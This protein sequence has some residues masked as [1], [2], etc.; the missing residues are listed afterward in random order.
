MAEAAGI[1]VVLDSGD[2][3]TLF[4]EDQARYLVACPF[5]AA[6]ALMVAAGHAGVHVETVGRF[7]GNAIKFG[8]AEAP[9]SDLAETFRGAFAEAVA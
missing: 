1:G 8:A 4:G 9:L 6:E 5:D 3:P 7:G 2:T